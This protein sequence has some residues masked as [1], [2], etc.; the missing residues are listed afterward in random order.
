MTFSTL[1]TF[2]NRR[3][4]SMVTSRRARWVNSAEVLRGGLWP[5]ETAEVD[6]SAHSVHLCPRPL[7]H[8]IAQKI[9][10]MTQP[11]ARGRSA[12]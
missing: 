2:A 7:R 12:E 10:G 4:S 8:H 3:I 9:H 1:Q 6:T 5:I 11:L